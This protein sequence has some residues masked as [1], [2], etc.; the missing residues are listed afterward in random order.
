MDRHVLIIPTESES[1]A[2]RPVNQF[3][4]ISDG[5]YFGLYLK[6]ETETIGIKQRNPNF[7]W[8]PEFKF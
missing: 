5:M 2:Q 1:V 6:S 3:F 7:T 8:T 4:F